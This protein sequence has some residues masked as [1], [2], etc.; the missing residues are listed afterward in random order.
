MERISA[1]LGGQSVVISAK[2]KQL[3]TSSIL[4]E[5]LVVSKIAGL[6]DRVTRS[7]GVDA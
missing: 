5:W 7:T 4:V 1:R 3:A 2:T 6:G